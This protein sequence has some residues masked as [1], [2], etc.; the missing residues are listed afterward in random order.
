M[1]KWVVNT[2]E[3]RIENGERIVTHGSHIVEADSAGEA[4]GSFKKFP[5][6]KIESVILLA[7]AKKKKK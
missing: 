6:E 3:H 1:K 4:R 2:S 7:E 5:Y